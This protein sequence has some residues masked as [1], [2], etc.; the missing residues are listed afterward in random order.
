MI[1]RGPEDGQGGGG[2]P[3]VALT[4][5]PEM[6]E[7][8]IQRKTCNTTD[9]YGVHF[10]TSIDHRIVMKQVKNACDRLLTSFFSLLKFVG[11][12]GTW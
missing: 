4:E 6:I 9:T 10:H 12:L 5:I 2:T 3:H 8:L 7:N 1:G 11:E